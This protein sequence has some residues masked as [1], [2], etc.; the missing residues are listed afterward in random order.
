MLRDYGAVK[1]LDWLADSRSS[2]SVWLIVKARRAAGVRISQE[3]PTRSPEE[4]SF[5]PL[6]SVWATFSLG[7]RSPVASSTRAP[8]TAP[9]EA[10]LG[11]FQGWVAKIQAAWEIKSAGDGKSLQASQYLLA[12]LREA[13]VDAQFLLQSALDHGCFS[14]L[15]EL[16]KAANELEG[17]N[18]LMMGGH[19]KAIYL[20]ACP[21]L[22]ECVLS[23]SSAS[24]RTL[25]KEEEELLRQLPL[26]NGSRR[27]PTESVLADQLGTTAENL[28]P[29]IDE[30]ERQGLMVSQL[31]VG[32]PTYSM[33]GKG[34]VYLRLSAPEI[35]EAS[36]AKG[37]RVRARDLG[38]PSWVRGGVRGP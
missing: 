17:M 4:P 34:W 23:V 16:L 32:G 22:F 18:L 33:S 26:T 8:T 24:E 10:D 7:L 29:R 12:S 31:R 19:N 27:G 1:Q 21:A 25:S 35:H 20:D 15:K 11:R 37:V 9:Q 3:Q 28:R 36:E 14:M 38:A 13:F 5:L 6:A 30:L 2:L